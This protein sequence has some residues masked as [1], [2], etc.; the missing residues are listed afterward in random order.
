MATST[1]FYAFALLATWLLLMQGVGAFVHPG[2]LRPLRPRVVCARTSPTITKQLVMAST[3][4]LAISGPLRA[5]AGVARKIFFALPLPFK[6]IATIL[7]T[8][9][10][11]VLIEDMTDYATSAVAKIRGKGPKEEAVA[12]VRKP[13]TPTKTS[14]PIRF[15][16]SGQDPIEYG[17]EVGA[18]LSVVAE[19][20]AVAIQYDCRKGQCGTCSIKV[21]SKWIKTCQT[22]VP[23]PVMPGEVFEVIVPQASIKSS[24]FFSPRSFLDGV[25]NNLLGMVGFVGQMQKADKQF[26]ARLAREKAIAEKARMKKLGEAKSG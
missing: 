21:G 26:Q 14:V 12:L 23:M 25:W 2:N 17:A 5:S 24:K 9:F 13:F 10:T 15:L 4:P 20:A 16:Q 8:L 18:K 7:T 22:S 11:L 19:D 3:I 6:L 1:N